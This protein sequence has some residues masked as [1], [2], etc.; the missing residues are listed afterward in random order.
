[1]VLT[2]E[3]TLLTR[4]AL[5]TGVTG[6]DGHYLA[7]HLLVNGYEVWGM[8]RGQANP[9]V[10]ALRR[11][12]PDLR[13]VNGD[14]L[15]QGNLTGVVA[16]VQP[17]EVYNLAAVSFVPLSWQQPDITNQVTGTGVLRMLEAIRAVGAPS[18]TPSE[19]GQIRFY[20]A[21]SSEMFGNAGQVPQNEDTPFRPCSPYGAAKA[22]GHFITT[23][24]REFYGMHAVSGIMFNHE[25]PR[26]GAEFVTRKISL[27]VARIKL[28]Q[29]SELRL[30]NLNARR[31]WGFAGDYVQAMRL[32]VAQHVA[33]DYVIG[34][35]RTHS[36]RELVELAFTTV[37]LDWRN[38]VVVDPALSRRAEVH[39]LCADAARAKKK[40][41]W[42]PVVSFEE[43]VAMMVEADLALLS[44][45]PSRDDVPVSYQHW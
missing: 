15:D 14:L 11:L 5:I 2:S 44:S 3:G 25:S 32:M 20:Q 27:A 42:Q 30:G 37:G 4:R 10:A 6:Q 35:G 9:R 21:S 24:Y 8:V 45:P 41:G 36:V 12:L 34:T 1:V 22:Y 23:N 43:L 40:L 33:D 31:D 17:D 29:A 28:G 16:R 13:I 18:G 38:H 7:E 19:V 39:I 26:R